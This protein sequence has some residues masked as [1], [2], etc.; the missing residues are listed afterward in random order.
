MQSIFTLWGLNELLLMYLPIINTSTFLL[1]YIEMIFSSPREFLR[2]TSSNQKI[3]VSI[4]TFMLNYWSWSESCHYKLPATCGGCLLFSLQEQYDD[5]CLV[6]AGS[7]NS[8]LPT[9][10][11][12]GAAKNIL[13]FMVCCLYV[14][15]LAFW[16]LLKTLKNFSFC[17]F[18]YISWRSCYCHFLS[19]CVMS[20]ALKAGL[21]WGQYVNWVGLRSI[22]LNIM[23]TL[24]PLVTVLN[25]H[26][27]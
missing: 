14:N 5:S 10:K 23:I 7:A 9:A 2:C 27:T 13:C 1:L 21:L 22:C 6:K 18:V 15:R 8:E 12:R 26:S 4:Q 17:I 20:L 24:N 11:Q 19:F 3:T 25:L 16:S